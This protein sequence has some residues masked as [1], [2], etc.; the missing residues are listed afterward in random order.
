MHQ[1]TVEGDIRVIAER[2]SRTYARVK[3]KVNFPNDSLQQ[4]ATPSPC[5]LHPNTH[6]YTHMGTQWMQGHTDEHTWTHGCIHTDAWTRTQV[7]AHS[8]M[9]TQMHEH[10]QECTHTWKHGHTQ[11]HGCA[12][13]HMDTPIKWPIPSLSKDFTFRTLR[14]SLNS[15]P[16]LILEIPSLLI[17]LMLMSR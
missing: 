5:C 12:H 14:L 7:Q 3:H 9:D 4:Y 11:M 16:L 10:T 1:V 2:Q 15:S 17:S 13:M 6:R 8:S